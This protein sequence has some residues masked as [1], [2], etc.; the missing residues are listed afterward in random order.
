LSLLAE[1]GEQKRDAIKQHFKTVDE[2]RMFW[3]RLL[4]RVDEQVIESMNDIE[5]LYQQE[6]SRDPGVTASRFWLEYGSDVELL[7]I[8]ALRMMQKAELVLHPA[9][10]PFEFIDLCRRDAER[11]SYAGPEQLKAKLSKAQRNKV[12]SICI[13][14]RKNE[15]VENPQL[16][17]LV[18]SANILHVVG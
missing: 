2:R 9:E 6:I 10:C 16:K 1:F 15:G 18:G 4:T 8:K 3:E 17:S 13:F 14:I 5:Q 12:N 7:S 11:Q